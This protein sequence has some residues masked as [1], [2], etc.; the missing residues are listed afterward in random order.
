MR[1]IS[2]AIF[3]APT[4]LMVVISPAIIA[5]VTPQVSTS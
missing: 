5:P 1:L 4:I 3:L 2:G